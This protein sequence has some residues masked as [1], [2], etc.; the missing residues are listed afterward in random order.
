MEPTP[1][2]QDVIRRRKLYEELVVRIEERI[3]RAEYRPGDQLPSEREL[4]EAYGVGRTS[5]R[6]ALF[7]LQ[8]MG[9]V[10]I[11]GGAR[12]RVRAPTA[13]ALVSELSGIARHLLSQPG[14]IEH[15]QQARVLLEVALARHAAA[16]A[17]EEQVARLGA[18]LDQ[19]RR[20]IGN[21]KE[22]E[23]TDVAFHYVLAEI[24]RNPIF[25]ALHE[26]IAQWLLEQRETSILARGS[27]QA[28]YRAHERIHAA[29][30][31]RDSDAAEQA[32][33]EHLA[34]VHGYYWQVR[35]A[36]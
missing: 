21:G 2:R 12:A 6:E 23:R 16:H 4:M 33:R 22:F 18:A 13:Q 20:A 24:P 1:I 35:G 25:T 36:R 15:F 26:A 9:L 34:Q 5:V 29:I 11:S 3:Q 17:T 19:N 8:K 30:V 28:A 27:A 31:A 32:M 7:A 10:T 14:G